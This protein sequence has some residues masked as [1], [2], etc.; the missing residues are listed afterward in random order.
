MGTNAEILLPFGITLDSFTNLY[1]ADGNGHTV[2]KMTLVGTNWNV[3]TIAGYP[4]QVIS[5][6]LDGTGTNALFGA[7]WGVCADSSGNLYVADFQNNNIRKITSAAV[8]T[9]LAGPVNSSSLS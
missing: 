7:P 5:G 8:V 6:S 3:T 1:V 4:N 2:R 9:T